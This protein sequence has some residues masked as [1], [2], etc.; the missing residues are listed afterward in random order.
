MSE[1]NQ[2]LKTLHRLKAVA[3]LGYEMEMDW[4]ESG[5]I[6]QKSGNVLYLD[7]GSS[8]PSIFNS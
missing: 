7:L 6:F 5:G 8:Y 1:K 3:S 4:E 2:T